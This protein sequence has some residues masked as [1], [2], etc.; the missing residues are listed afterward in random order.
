MR[1]RELVS[2]ASLFPIRHILNWLRD[3][4]LPTLDHADSQELLREAEYFQLRVSM[5][6]LV[7]SG[8]SGSP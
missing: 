1:L 7:L 5:S 6:L 4:A 8:N 2:Y 3:G